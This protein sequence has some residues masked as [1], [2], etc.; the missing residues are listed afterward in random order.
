MLQQSNPPISKQ[1]LNDRK[2]Y[3]EQH[4]DELPQGELKRD[5]EK[6]L[7]EMEKADDLYWITNNSSLYGLKKYEQRYPRGKHI[8]EIITRRYQLE[9]Q[10]TERQEQID[11][12]LSTTKSIFKYGGLTVCAGLFVL[13]IYTAINTDSKITWTT[14][15]PLFYITYRLKEW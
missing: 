14:L 10:V 3:L 11:D 12:A 1:V 7:K 13:V 4:C 9:R 5:T 8:S 2:Q 15:G 6:T